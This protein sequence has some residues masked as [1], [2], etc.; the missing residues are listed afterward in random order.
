MTLAIVAKINKIRKG[1]DIIICTDEIKSG[2]VKVIIILTI[3]FILRSSEIIFMI[4]S[5]KTDE[6]DENS[7]Q[8]TNL[9]NEL[10]TIKLYS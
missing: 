10:G 5:S 6:S 7:S 8:I 2:I 3:N 4:K 1:K 9:K